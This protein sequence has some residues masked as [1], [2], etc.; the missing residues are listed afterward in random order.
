MNV[1]FLLY[2]VER[3]CE[4]Y[5]ITTD[6]ALYLWKNSLGEYLKEKGITDE[7]EDNY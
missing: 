1:C 2:T 7:P 5:G 4:K 6:N 3:D